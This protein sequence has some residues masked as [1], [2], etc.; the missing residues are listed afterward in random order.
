MNPQH[1]ISSAKPAGDAINVLFFLPLVG[2]AVS[3]G[4]NIYSTFGGRLESSEI[5]QLVSLGTH[6]PTFIG[7]LLIGFLGMKDWRCI[8]MVLLGVK[9]LLSTGYFFLYAFVFPQVEFSTFYEV[10]FPIYGGLLALMTLIASI[11]LIV[12]KKG[13]SSLVRLSGSIFLL[14]MIFSYAAIPAINWLIGEIVDIEY[15]YV[16]YVYQGINLISLAFPA[17]GWV[18]LAMGVINERSNKA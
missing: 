4:A 1:S 16:H 6:L 3:L 2:I 5:G 7:A 11:L 15:S 10:I 9:A 8:A 13:G 17:V 14:A 12:N 18:T